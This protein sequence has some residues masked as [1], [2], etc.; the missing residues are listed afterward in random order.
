MM[1]SVKNVKEE[2]LKNMASQKGEFVS[3]ETYEQTCHALFEIIEE[4]QNRNKL[5][6]EKV[7]KGLEEE[8]IYKNYEFSPIG[9][10]RAYAIL[11][12]N[13]NITE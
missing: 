10:F 4:L 1:E 5:L 8:N 12:E 2:I 3:K 13:K 9:M 7:D 11:E 6:E